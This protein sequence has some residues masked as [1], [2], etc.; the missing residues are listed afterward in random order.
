MSRIL[1][2]SVSGYQREATP[3]PFSPFLTSAAPGAMIPPR[4][5]RF[6]KS[7]WKALERLL[8]A[9]FF[10]SLITDCLEIW[11]P[12]IRLMSHSTSS[13]SIV[14]HTAATSGSISHNVT[15]STKFSATAVNPMI[16]P[17]ANGSTNS[18]GRL[19][20]DLTHSRKN[21]TN[22]VLPP[23]Y[24]NGLRCGTPAVLTTFE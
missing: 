7:A 11:N 6:R 8:F 3:F 15:L 10:N 12:R 13:P 24:R 16:P 18:R 14:S 20:S 23:G 5:T 2:A 22:Q 9:T 19:S 21:G 17:P 4:C 1:R